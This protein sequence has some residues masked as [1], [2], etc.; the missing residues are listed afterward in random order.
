[1]EDLRTLFESRY[2]WIAGFMRNVAR[3]GRRVA[4]ISPDEGKEW[5]YSSLNEEADRLAN[6]RFIAVHCRR[7]LYSRWARSSSG[8]DALR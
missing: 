3:Y 5:T 2:T 1:M 6:A 8:A 7:A 4:M